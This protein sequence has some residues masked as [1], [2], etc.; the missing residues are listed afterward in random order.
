[1]RELGFETFGE[2]I[3]E[4]Y[5]EEPD[6]RRRF[7]LAYAEVRR[8]CALDETDLARRICGVAD[9]LEHNARHAL[10]EMPGALRRRRDAELLDE[11]LG[12]VR[13]ETSETVTA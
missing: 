3:D 10:V 9:K 2:L 7:E 4:S 12:A 6:P 11:I 8:L 5:D 13:A 1:V